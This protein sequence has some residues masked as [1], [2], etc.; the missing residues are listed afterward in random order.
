[1][2]D[3]LHAVR[4]DAEEFGPDPVAVVRGRRRR[5]M[6]RLW[7]LAAVVIS[8]GAVAVLA[9]AWPIVD[10]PL[11][12]KLQ[13]VATSPPAAARAASQDEIDRLRREADALASEISELKQAQQQAA[14]TIAAL[15]AAEQE[16]RKQVPPPE[17]LNFA[18]GSPPQPGAVLTPPPR[19]PTARRKTRGVVPADRR[20]PLSLQ[21]PQ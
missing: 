18:A 7:T 14:E 8:A 9:L 2:S 4:L 15:R 11:R 10:R 21:G 20:A 16:A 12:L 3:R 6:Q 13:S 1:M 5:I 19:P 17:A